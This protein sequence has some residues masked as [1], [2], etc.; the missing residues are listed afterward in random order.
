MAVRA[1]VQVPKAVR[2][3]EVFEVR[4]TLAH[5]METGYRRDSGGRMLPRDIVRT[6][7]VR[8]AGERVFAAD[9]HPAIAANPFFA[10]TLVANA[11]GPLEIRWVGDNGFVHT[12][13]VTLVV[14]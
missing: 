3:G 7:E 14:T 9:L 5:P 13:T 8:L 1:L 10:F 11:G 6:L 12:E 4:T 2:R